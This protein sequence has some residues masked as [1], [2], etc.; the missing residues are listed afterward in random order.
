ME[1]DHSLTDYMYNFID[2]IC[3]Q[4]GPRYSCST[5]EKE[6]NK[7]IK[8][9]FTRYCDETYLDE[10]KTKPGLY[11]Q[12]LIKVAGIFSAFSPIF[13]PLVFPL[14]IL[15]SIFIFMALFVLI[16]ELIMMKEWIDFL[17]KEKTSSNVSGIIKPTEE[18]K[19]RIIVESHTDS[20]KEMN[21][22][23]MNETLRYFIGVIGVVFL[24]F[25]IVFSIWK[26]IA[27]IIVGNS[28]ILFQWSIF[29]ITFL[30][31]IYFFSLIVLYPFFLL[32]VKGFLGKTVV[33][34][35]NDNLAATAVAAGIGKY[36]RENRP[37]HVEVWIV[38]QGSE[39]VGDKGARAFVEKYGEKGYLDN[40]YTLVLECC[41]AADAML[42]VEKDMHRII[43]DKEMNR[44]LKSVYDELQSKDPNL[45]DLRIDKLKI[46]ACDAV[47]YLENG[48]Q[49]TALFGV[50]KNKNKAVNWHS[51]KDG[52]ENI[53]K[54]VLEDFLKISLLFIQ[55]VDGGF[56]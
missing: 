21:I 39:E 48:Y 16:S 25:S 34:G 36:L 46:G 54:R 5:Q 13:I 31:Y 7:W 20:A 38:S 17:F 8:E 35:A 23:S 11:P 49:A 22:A 50:E 51:V 43:Y 15:T 12:G 33:M 24:I 19:F 26:F 14:P 1:I 47:R 3:K 42:L 28:M 9:E 29:T 53:E 18:V 4:F 40:S 30:D 27:L 56:H 32:L 10:F 55:K 2:K 6:A 44:K 45:L 37:K 52:P 41:G